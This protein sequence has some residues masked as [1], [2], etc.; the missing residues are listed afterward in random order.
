MNAAGLGHIPDRPETLEERLR[1]RP[2]T[3]LVGRNG[4]GIQE[5]HD[6]REL[7]PLV[8]QQGFTESCVAQSW[9]MAAYMCGEGQARRAE[10]EG[11]DPTPYRIPI[12]SVLQA[13]MMA[14][15]E[16][17][18]LE[19]LDQRRVRNQGVRVGSLVKALRTS[20][21]VSESRFV[22]DLNQ[23]ALWDTLQRGPEMPLDVDIAAAD[24]LL[25]GDYGIGGSAAPFL[26][27]MALDK[28]H[29]PAIAFHVDQSFMD[30]RGIEVEFSD[31][32]GPPMGRH[33]MVIVGSRPGW[34]LVKNSWGAEW[35]DGG[36]AW[37]SDDYIIARHAACETVV[38][39]TA[40]RLA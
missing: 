15:Y 3:G 37:V 40:P 35:G 14:Q 7:C 10:L 36:Y 28:W 5:N 8:F 6:L 9:A 25:T 4:A 27:R 12:P 20:G 34:I 2:L 1:E 31:M 13:W 16:D 38:Y 21:V 23:V 24:A 30:L 32:R 29:I 22:L 11:R 33:M 18:A 19:P 39:T 17:M 26:I